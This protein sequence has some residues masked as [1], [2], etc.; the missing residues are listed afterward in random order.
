MGQL[1]FYNLYNTCIGNKRI[2]KIPFF[3]QLAKIQSF[4]FLWKK[5]KHLLEEK[6]EGKLM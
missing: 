6:C 1:V 3:K 2:I 5:S 4:Q